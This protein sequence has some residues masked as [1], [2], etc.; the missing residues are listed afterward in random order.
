[1]R[2][3]E[4]NWSFHTILPRNQQETPLWSPFDHES[5]GLVPI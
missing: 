2:A 4:S 1:M 3:L 5:V